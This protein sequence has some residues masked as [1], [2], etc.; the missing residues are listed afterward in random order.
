[1]SGGSCA[2]KIGYL[3]Q[4]RVAGAG[5]K[6]QRHIQCH[7]RRHIQRHIVSA[8]DESGSPALNEMG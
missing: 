5:E 7:I 1:M 3:I 4:V 8:A 2:A 6:I